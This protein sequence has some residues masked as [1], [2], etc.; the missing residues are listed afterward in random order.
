[1]ELIKISISIIFMLVGTETSQKST[2][3]GATCV[4]TITLAEREY[5]LTQ[6]LNIKKKKKRF[7][8]ANL[9]LLTATKPL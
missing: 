4:S 6:E 3:V 9:K 8:K 2:V 7:V 5:I 1:M